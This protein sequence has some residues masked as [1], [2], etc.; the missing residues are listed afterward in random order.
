MKKFFLFILTI[1]SLCFVTLS[2]S[3]NKENSKVTQE[4]QEPQEPQESKESK[5]TKLPIS[6]SENGDNSCIVEDIDN[7][8]EENNKNNVKIKISNEDEDNKTKKGW[9]SIFVILVI[10]GLSYMKFKEMS[11]TSN[12]EKNS[13]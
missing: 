11:S 3:D 8:I 7:E 5:E 9:F 4:P 13:E 10:L 1:F 2:A 12:K 6:L